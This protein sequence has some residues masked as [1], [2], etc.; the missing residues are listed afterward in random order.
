MIVLKTKEGKTELHAAGPAEL[1]Q[2]ELT[3]TNMSLVKALSN[4]KHIS[5]E[6]ASLLL[7]QESNRNYAENKEYSEEE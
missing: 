7:M 5:F 6:A 4:L 2:I 3:T 1:L